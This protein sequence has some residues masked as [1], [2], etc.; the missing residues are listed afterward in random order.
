MI[1]ITNHF[2]SDFTSHHS[3]SRPS[4]WISVLILQYIPEASLSIKHWF[5]TTCYRFFFLYF[6]VDLIFLNLFCIFPTASQ[7]S[8]PN[9]KTYLIFSSLILRV[10]FW[11]CLS[12]LSDFIFLDILKFF[13]LI[14][15]SW[16][17]ILL[18]VFLFISHYPLYWFWISIWMLLCILFR[19]LIFDVHVHF[20]FTAWF[21]F[22]VSLC[23]F[24]SN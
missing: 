15:Y 1:V 21:C 24:I 12:F 9:F 19:V 22:S 13:Q 7:D 10:P 8:L 2:I 18:W 17:Q 5:F 6:L 20:Y 4:Q 11:S 14:M 16:C 23:A 3:F